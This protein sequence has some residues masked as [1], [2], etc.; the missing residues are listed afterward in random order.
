MQRPRHEGELSCHAAQ[1]GVVAVDWLRRREGLAGLERCEAFGHPAAPGLQGDRVR[2]C[3]CR[4][5]LQ[6]E[7]AACQA[8]ECGVDHQGGLCV[9]PGAAAGFLQG[10][11]QRGFQVVA[12]EAGCAAH[13][14][15]AVLRHGSRCFEGRQLQVGIGCVGAD[16][17]EQRLA[18]ADGLPARP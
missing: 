5:V 10:S 3:L 6:G 8:A 12:G 15:E 11:V 4:V 13:R 18:H 17:G 9:W 14:F 7:E 16:C 2:A 1:R